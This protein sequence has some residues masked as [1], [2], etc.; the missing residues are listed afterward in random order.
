MPLASVVVAKVITRQCVAPLDMSTAAKD[1]KRSDSKEK[2]GHE[3]NNGGKGNGSAQG[4]R[5]WKRQ[6]Q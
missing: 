1:S 4:K 6:D 5:Y 3:N 2:K